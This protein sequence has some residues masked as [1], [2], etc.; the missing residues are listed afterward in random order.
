[1]AAEPEKV[2]SARPRRPLVLPKWLNLKGEPNRDPYADLMKET[3]RGLATLVLAVPGFGG[4]KGILEPQPETALPN[5]AD[6]VSDGLK[7]VTDSLTGTFD[8]LLR[9]IA[10]EDLA[11]KSVLCQPS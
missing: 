8:I 3:G 10:M 2:A 5:W 9:T 6:D 1:M 7:P 11:S 4:R